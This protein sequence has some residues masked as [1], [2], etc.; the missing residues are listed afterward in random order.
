MKIDIHPQAVSSFNEQGLSLV[1]RCEEAKVKTN[2]AT[3]H[4]FPE[5]YVTTTLTE[6]DIDGD[7]VIDWKNYI[8]EKISRGFICQGKQIDLGQDAYKDFIKLCEKIRRALKPQSIISQSAVENQAFNWISSRYCG[9][10]DVGLIDY[11]LPGLA[12]EIQELEIWIPVA[13]LHIESDMPIG[14][15]VFKPISK[16][17]IE[18]WRGIAL[19]QI[20]IPEDP[21]D[22]KRE[23]LFGFYEMIQKSTRGG[24]QG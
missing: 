7:I 16:N 4:N 23:S 12:A 14:K 24:Q 6:K 22:Q 21:L 15:V 13:Q 19:S 5:V 17:I 20:P 10:I 9:S 8:G 2:P 11:I 1:A 18:H 3:P